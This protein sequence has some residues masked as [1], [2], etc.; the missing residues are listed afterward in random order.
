MAATLESPLLQ[1]A[2]DVH[3]DA[4][5]RLEALVADLT[6][7]QA[8]WKPSP[9]AWSVVECLDHLGE[10]LGR[11]AGPMDAAIRKARE[12]GR[13]GSEPYG[14]G[15]LAGRFLVGFLSHPAKKAPAPGVFQPASAEG[16]EL[17]AVAEDLRRKVTGLIEL[18]RR[19][20]GLPLG[21]IRIATPISGLIR[22]S[23]AQ[24]FEVHTLHTPRHLAQA[25]RVVGRDGFPG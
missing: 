20:D 19:A 15:T 22:V 17:G 11:Y 18:A 2:V 6:D 24:A 1:K 10:S 3:E 14:R 9:K 16:L 12:E 21:S 5:A 23:L 7:E 25:E 13:T 8:R 4:L